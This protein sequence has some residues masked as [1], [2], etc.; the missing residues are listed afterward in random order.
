VAG[1][2]AGLELLRSATDERCRARLHAGLAALTLREAGL[3]VTEPAAAIVSVTAP[4][5]SAAASWAAACLERGVAVGCFRPPSTPDT[6]SRLRLTTGASVPTSD[7]R[8]A[9]RVVVETAP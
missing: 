5:A 6:R 8:R 2:L 7:F 4:D 1:A 3:E 9:L